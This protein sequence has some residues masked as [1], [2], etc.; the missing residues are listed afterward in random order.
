MQ[1]YSIC[2][3]DYLCARACWVWPNVH[4]QVEVE[5]RVTAKTELFLVRDHSNFDAAWP[6][7]FGL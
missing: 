1:A 2:M 3:Y 6:I 4:V 7:R 5:S